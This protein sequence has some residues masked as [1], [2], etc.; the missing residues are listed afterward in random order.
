[1]TIQG[2]LSLP[3]PPEFCLWISLIFLFVDTNIFSFLF[4][5]VSTGA[6]VPVF[7]IDFLTSIL[8]SGA[9]S[10]R[11]ADLTLYL[12]GL[13]GGCLGRSVTPVRRREDTNGNGDAGVKVQI[14]WLYGRLTLE[15]L[16]KLKGTREKTKG[17]GEKVFGYEE[18]NFLQALRS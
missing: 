7:D 18:L 6:V 13:R 4:L 11:R 9:C 2:S 8:P 3:I 15:F 1:M 16:S 5:L 17:E 12:C 14:D 10:A